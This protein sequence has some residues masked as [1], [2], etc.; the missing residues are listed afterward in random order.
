MRLRVKL[1]RAAHSGNMSYFIHCYYTEVIRACIEIVKG[2]V[3]FF[4]FHLHEVDE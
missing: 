3:F 2:G 4:V 1:F